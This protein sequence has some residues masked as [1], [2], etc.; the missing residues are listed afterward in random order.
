MK[1]AKRNIP[2]GKREERRTER[3]NSIIA[4]AGDLFRTDGYHGVS[5]SAVVSRM[6][7]SKE[8]LWRHF[9]SKEELFSAYIESAM[10]EFRDE[11]SVNLTS[12]TRLEAGLLKFATSFLDKVAH[13][14][15]LALYQLII[16][17][18]GRSPEVG[19]IFYAN[20]Q[21]KTERA[22][23]EFLE[24]KIEGGKHKAQ[25]AADLFL[26]LCTGNYFMKALL[27][28]TKPTAA[29]IQSEA[30]RYVRNFICCYPPAR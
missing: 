27:G 5:M 6:G 12:A 18:C 8:T 1:R 11:L 23:T 14:D 10:Q 13:A 28:I 7:G 2:G 4:I 29:G 24:G 16:G 26:T 9:R 21:L 25:E 15:S 22:L 3:R 17:E 30:A 19:K 20:V